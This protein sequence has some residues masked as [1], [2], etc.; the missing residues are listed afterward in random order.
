LCNDVIDECMP[1]ANACMVVSTTF[2]HHGGFVQ[3]DND[4][5]PRSF[6]PIYPAARIRRDKQCQVTAYDKRSL[7]SDS[8]LVVDVSG[9]M[10]GNIRRLRHGI[11]RAL[12]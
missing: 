7:G 4:G 10:A 1:H 3:R 8:L 12:L 9:H 6:V 11:C 2:G 5:W